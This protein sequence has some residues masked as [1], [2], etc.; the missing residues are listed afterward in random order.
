MG[1]KWECTG[2]SSNQ[3]FY[4]RYCGELNFLCPK[5]VVSIYIALLQFR[6]YI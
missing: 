4:Q 5:N 3:E 2:D 6:D 1:L